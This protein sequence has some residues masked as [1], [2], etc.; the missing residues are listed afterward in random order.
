[1]KYI[2]ASAFASEMDQYLK[3]LHESGRYICRI[4]SSLRSLDKYLTSKGL[5]CQTLAAETVSEWI[6]MRNVSSST[7]ASDI[8][9]VKGFSTFLVSLGFD[10]DCPEAPKVQS[11]YVPYVF[12]DAE[13]KRI[14][15]VADNFEAGKKLTR[16]ALLFPFLLRLLYGCGL[17]L[18]EGLSLRWSDVDLDGGVITIRKAKNRKQRFVPMDKSMAS[19]LKNCKVMTRTDGICEDYLFESNFTPGEPF[20]NNTFYEWFRKTLEGAGIHYTK[21]HRR[22]R[23]PCPHCLRH[24]FTLKSF[25]KSEAE[26]RR[27]EDTAP[28]LAAYLGHDSPKE[29]EAYLR[30]NHTVYTMSH[31]RLNAS[32]GHVFPEVNFDEN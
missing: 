18:G 12:S 9:N 26:G 24:C 2:F 3:L 21:C 31:K 25:L 13:I 5:T 27:F 30:S 10:S 20:R 23:G 6:K 28:F 4:Q 17:R 29:T 19:L 15:S 11:C 16:S 32:V 22:E 1:M 14:I 7:K 8:C